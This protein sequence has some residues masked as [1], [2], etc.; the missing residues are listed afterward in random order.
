MKIRVAIY[1]TETDYIERLAGA[2]HVKY[3]EK[4]EVYCFTDAGLFEKTLSEGGINVV[5]VSEAT[6]AEGIT[7]P[8]NAVMAYLTATQGL[9][10]IRGCEAIFKYQR[11]DLIYQAVLALFA[12]IDAISVVR[13]SRFSSNDCAVIGFSSVSGGAGATSLAAACAVHFA[14]ER[15]RTVYL[16]FEHLDS[17]GVLFHGEGNFTMSKVIFELK[18]RLSGT[19]KSDGGQKS[20]LELIL[21]SSVRQDAHGVYFY[22]PADIAPDMWELSGEEKALLV[23]TVKNSGNYDRVIVDIESRFNNENIALFR[24]LDA[25][26]LVHRDHAASMY[27]LAQFQNAVAAMESQDGRIFA[28][29]MALQNAVAQKREVREQESGMRRLSPVPQMPHAS[30]EELYE[31]LQQLEVF[32]TILSDSEGFEQ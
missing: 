17:T 18:M 1:D 12:E 4:L 22:A 25:M 6:Q 10:K 27:K 26:V 31:K 20:K 14:K 19:D 13:Q 28:S 21:E 3:A 7:V 29:V 23:E 9:N 11:V 2:F 16:N 32:D 24:Q 8:A 30:E 15:Y 5:L